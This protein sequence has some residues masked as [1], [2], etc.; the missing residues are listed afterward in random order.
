MT[1][2]PHTDGYAARRIHLSFAPWEA[3]D[4]L[5]DLPGGQGVSEATRRL[6]RTLIEARRQPPPAAPVIPGVDDGVIYAPAQSVRPA[7]EQEPV[8][9]WILRKRDVHGISGVGYIGIYFVSP[10]GAAAYRWFG[11]PPQDQPKWE[12]YDN[13]GTAPFE[14]IS[15][16]SG[17]TVLIPIPLAKDPEPEPEPDL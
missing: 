4:I 14:Q 7:P 1:E 3:D 6:H 12:V 11:G 16:H 8:L 13:P 15:G 2:R 9:G 5:A 17:D 10:D